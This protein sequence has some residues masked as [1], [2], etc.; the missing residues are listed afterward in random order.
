M[1][2]IRQIREN[3]EE[4]EKALRRRQPDLSLEP[5]LELDRQKREMLHRA[6]T[7]RNEQKT[8]SKQIGQA[9][10]KGEDAGEV[11]E[12]VSSIK[13]EIASLE[14]PLKETEEKLDRLLAELPNVPHPSVPADMD[15]KNNVE[16]RREGEIR[17]FDFEPKNHLELSE[18]LG[19]FDLAR[20]AKI[21]GSQWPMYT[22]EGARLELALLYFMINEN[23]KKGFTLVLPPLL[24]NAQSMFTSGNLP[25]FADQLYKCQD[26][27]LYLIPTSEVPLTSLYRDEILSEEN[28]PLYYCAMTPCFRR[29]AGTYGAEER[30][31]VR[32]HQFNKVE[33]YKYTTPETSYDEL[34]TLT[35]AAENLVSRL[36]LHYRTMLLVTG[37]I[38]QQAAKTYDVEVWLPG[39][40]AYYEV[41]SCSNCEDYQARRG[42]I[43]YRPKAE[44]GEKTRPRFVHT[45]NGS[46]LATS[47][48]MVSILENY[49]QADGSVMIPEVLRPWMGGQEKIEPVR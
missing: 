10:Q 12:K 43:R 26:D 5:L 8:L 37:D 38:G 9:R 29:E 39:Q 18:S 27:P 7:L 24:V 45:L 41:S 15:K 1:L 17:Q 49:Q 33:M 4:F 19:L 47:R 2:D 31:L 28:L 16:V 30:G 6:E 23:V 46:G 48:L 11:M 42:N 36:G 20:A 35:A 34:E 21:S 44:G 32:M 25:K 40:D 14:E 3:P 22:G 13:Q